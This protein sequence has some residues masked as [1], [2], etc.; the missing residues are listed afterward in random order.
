M[1]TSVEYNNLSVGDLVR[2]QKSWKTQLGDVKGTIKE[3]RHYPGE[4]TVDYVIS[5]DGEDC[6]LGSWTIEPILSE[7]ID[8]EL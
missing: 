2:P 3:I 1:S 8:E 4:K 5:F 7:F 6:L